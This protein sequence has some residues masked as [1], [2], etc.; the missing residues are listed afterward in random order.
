MIRSENHYMIPLRE[1]EQYGG[2]KWASLEVD[3]F[4]EEFCGGVSYEALDVGRVQPGYIIDAEFK[5]PY[6]VNDLLWLGCGA[7][8]S[9]PQ[10]FMSTRHECERR[11]ELA[12]VQGAK[13]SKRGST[14]SQ[15]TGLCAPVDVHVPRSQLAGRERY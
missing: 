15:F 13:H 11:F 5:K 1:L 2:K 7:G 3:L 10:G 14:E 6:L 12:D 9:S 4:G 8:D